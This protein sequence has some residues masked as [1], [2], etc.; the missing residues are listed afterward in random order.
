MPDG[1]RFYT[2]KEAANLLEVNYS[3]ML[4][5]L[6]RG[7][8]PAVTVNGRNVGVLKKDFWRICKQMEE[9][10]QIWAGGMPQAYRDER[11]AFTAE[12]NITRHEKGG[13]NHMNT[14]I[15]LTSEQT[16]RAHLGM[17]AL[18]TEA[19]DNAKEHGFHK[20]YDELIANVPREELQAM[21][22]T[23]LLAK[24][25][26]ITS[27]VGEAVSALQHDDETAF[28]EEVADIVIRVLD[29]CGAE[30]IDLGGEVLN[31]MRTNRARPYLHGKKC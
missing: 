10:R 22:R 9:D 3:T 7:V 28:A 1:C 30:S 19:Y 16:L 20:I 2:I 6:K 5:R 29:L 15:T 4:M 23:I 18:V 27:E 26:L 31:K 12:E 24:L 21:R 11:Q 8:F 13:Q 25:A 17:A 14:K